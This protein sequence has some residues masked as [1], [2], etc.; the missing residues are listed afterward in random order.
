[1][2]ITINDK[3]VIKELDRF[4]HDNFLIKDLGHFKYFLGVEVAYSKQGIVISQR[5]YTLNI[6]KDASM[7]EAK[8]TKFSMEQ[9]QKLTLSNSELLKDLSQYRRLIGHLI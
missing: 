3:I 2:I 5:I 4:L 6:L 7:I 8:P 1:M 9:N